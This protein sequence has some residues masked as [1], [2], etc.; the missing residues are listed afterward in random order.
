MGYPHLTVCCKC[1]TFFIVMN[2]EKPKH[3]WEVYKGTPNR[4][5]TGDRPRVTLNS[6]KVFLLN[7]KACEILGDPAA[8]ELRYDEDTRTIGFAPMDLRIVSAFPLKDHKAR[9]YTYRII[10]ASPFC[11]QFGI[12]PRGT[13]LF[14]E[15]EMDNEGTLMLELSTAVPV[16]R[17]FR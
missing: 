9:K 10:H 14:T 6:R 8:V 17:G 2:N 1:E 15:I 5:G 12:T 16:G 13:L 4:V 3:R 7:K 11:K